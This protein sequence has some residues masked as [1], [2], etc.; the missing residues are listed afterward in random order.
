M[1]EDACVG[2]CVEDGLF[3]WWWNKNRS[4]KMNEQFSTFAVKGVLVDVDAVVFVG[5]IWKS[6]AL[7]DENRVTDCCRW[8]WQQSFL[9]ETVRIFC[10]HSFWSFV[11][12]VRQ[13]CN[14]CWLVWKDHKNSKMMMMMMNSVEWSG[15]RESFSGRLTWTCLQMF[16]MRLATMCS[17]SMPSLS[18]QSTITWMIRGILQWLTPRII[19]L[20]LQEGQRSVEIKRHWTKWRR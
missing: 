9:Y 10:K 16:I 4:Q 7:S 19:S 6:V 18:M 5:W 12:M 1:C 13:A 20:L 3:E 15:Q 11:R 17:I 2:A 14:I 8:W